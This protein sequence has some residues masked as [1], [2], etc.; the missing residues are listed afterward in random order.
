[1]NK[2]EECNEVKVSIPLNRHCNTVDYLKIVKKNGKYGIIQE[3]FDLNEAKT[4]FILANTNQF[5]DFEYDSIEQIG[6]GA[7]FILKQGDEYRL[8]DFLG[9]DYVITLNLLTGEYKEI[10]LNTD[11]GVDIFI[12]KEREDW[13]QIYIPHL[14][15]LTS[16]CCSI[17]IENNHMITYT[18]EFRVEVMSV[19]TGKLICRLGKEEIKK[20]FEL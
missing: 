9:Y 19:D 5:I 6:S 10:E 16:F 1:M 17:R 15:H 8:C 13:F 3:E 2:Y 7:T 18:E 12:M 4:E 11:C 14:M 20:Y